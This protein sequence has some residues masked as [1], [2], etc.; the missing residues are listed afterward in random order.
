M[1]QKNSP[2]VTIARILNTKVLAKR[3]M[4]TSAMTFAGV[5]AMASSAFAV[6]QY[7]T[8]TGGGSCWW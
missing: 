7:E 6:G 2:V 4:A 1:A 5:V 3:L 8:P